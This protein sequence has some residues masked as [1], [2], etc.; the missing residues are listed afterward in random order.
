M[1]YSSYRYIYPPRPK[2]AIPQEDLRGFD[3][4]SMFA[5]IKLDGSN[6]L[7]FTDGKTIH[8]MNRHAQ[9]MTRFEIPDEEVLSLYK[10][11]GGWTVLNGE[12]MNK[13]KRDASGRQFNHKLAIFDILVN[14][15][16]YLI[17]KTFEQRQSILASMFGEKESE[18]DF[19]FSITDSVYRV[20]SYFSGF[21]EIYRRLV[22]I[23]M[24]EGV[25]LKRKAARLEMGNT[26]L[27]NTRSQ[28]KCRKATKNYRF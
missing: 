26:E 27:N 8:V 18:H 7:I 1:R 17:G 23:D 22:G 11:T 25:V 13:N 5:S 16:D 20:R 24:V 19:L 21:D 4:G 2:N 14:D 12:Y 28:L 10:G 6:C 3:N 9:R 15:G